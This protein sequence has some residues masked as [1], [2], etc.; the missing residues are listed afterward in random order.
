MIVL[1]LVGVG[2]AG[3]G[4]FGVV[5]QYRSFGLSPDYSEAAALK[6]TDS[7]IVKAA[8]APDIHRGDLVMFDFGAFPDVAGVHGAIL[9]RVIGIGGDTVSC[10]D[11]TGHTRVNGKSVIEPYAPGW[12]HERGDIFAPYSAKVPAGTIFVAGDDRDHS[13]DSRL[14]IDEPGAGTIPVS[15]VYGVVVATG[16]R[17][18][19]QP[20]TPTTAFTDAG[21]EGAATPGDDNLLNRILLA[22]GLALLFAGVLGVIVSVIRSGGKRRLPA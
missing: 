17:F 2:V 14:Y 9:K 3:F 11:G 10:C 18:A 7:V 1:A 5:V 6:D 4:A 22:A 21:L 12:G 8:D 13:R 15:S 16:D 20:L 19:P